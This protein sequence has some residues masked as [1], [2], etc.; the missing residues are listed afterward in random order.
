MTVTASTRKAGPYAGNGVA[1]SFPFYFKV[2]DKTGAQVVLTDTDGVATVLVL[3]S[4]YSIALSTDQ[5]SAPGGTITYPISGSP[6]A[7]GLTLTAIGGVP[8]DQATDITNAGRFL[9]QVIENALDKVTILIQQLKEVSD[10]TLQ[11]AV[12]TTVKLLFPAPSSGKYLR[13]RSD[14]TGLEN[15]DAGTDS[16]AL[17]GLLADAALAAHGAG[18]IGYGSL[19]SY[20][21]GTIGWKLLQLPLNVRDFGAVG[22]G[23]TNDSAAIQAALD[24]L[25]L[26]GSGSLY[27]PGGR[28]YKA[29]GLTWTGTTDARLSIFGDGASTRLMIAANSGNLL[30]CDGGSIDISDME[31]GH[32]VH[33]ASTGGYLFSFTNSIANLRRL[34]VYNGYN[35]A[36]WGAGCN[37]CGAVD[38]LARGVKNDL[39]GVDV[40][41]ILP[42]TQQHGNITFERVRSQAYGTNTGAG[43]R[44]VSGDGVFLSHVQ[45]HGYQ[46]G[47]IAQTSAARSYLANLFFDQ[48]IIDGA[49][50]PAL[51]GPGV[52]FD[53]TN[54]PLLRIYFSNSW[55]GAFANG[56]GLYTKNTKVFSWR[57]GSIIDNSHEGVMFDVGCED[58]SVFGSVITGNGLS[59]PNTYAG[60]LVYDADGILIADNRIGA[61]H[62]SNDAVTKMNT[63]KY[64]VHVALPST[65]NY[66]VYDNDL[67]DN[68][69]FGFQDGGGAGGRKVVRDN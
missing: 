37:Q 69:T 35:V 67:R 34:D 68:L 61:T 18:M 27:L 38:I 44:I 9:P 66:S 55:I 1:T 52:Y 45:V 59:S 49:G 28:T 48:V 42:P 65:V 22:D 23:V 3:D 4:D 56:A 36:L 46:N 14:L 19:L 17:Q 64:G 47:I 62:N 12:G 51:A 2:F 43:F 21:P 6:M 16:M 11:A 30:T 10:R 13:W 8:Y 7:A 54:N 31:V 29:A 57:N 63:Q 33:D 26:R 58:C 41:P 25:A 15:V 24:V 39:F 20:P 50:G 5:D 53:G 32:L 60:I 40:S